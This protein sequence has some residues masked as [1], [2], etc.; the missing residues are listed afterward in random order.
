MSV[1]E[2]IQLLGKGL[3]KDIPDTLTLTSIP[4]ACELDY[5]GGED[6][7]KIMLEKIFPAAIVEK[8]NFGEL[9]QIDYH[10]ICRCLRILNYGPYY[11]TNRIFCNDCGETSNGEFQVNLN[12]IDCVPLPEGFKNSITLSKDEFIDFNG[13][14]TF[15]LPTITE[16]NAAYVDKAFENADGTFNRPLARMCYMITSI[17]GQSGMI[18]LEIKNKIQREFSAADYIILKDRINELSNYGLRAVGSC[19]CPHCGKTT[20]NYLALVDDRFFRPTVGNLK[21]WR[22]DTNKRK[23]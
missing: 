9:L 3:Y 18:P 8:V 21:K 16:I 5:V 7:D 1:T 22:D 13:D 17:N 10:W 2:K 6:F 19:Q 4:T 15:K 11:T 12:T 23:D 20:A 14:V